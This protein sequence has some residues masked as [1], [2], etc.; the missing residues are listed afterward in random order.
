[1]LYLYTPKNYKSII[2]R[3]KKKTAGEVFKS[4]YQKAKGM[5]LIYVLNMFPVNRPRQTKKKI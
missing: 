5:C 1:M 3:V 4:K 2:L